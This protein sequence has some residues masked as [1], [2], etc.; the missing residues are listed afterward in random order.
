MK[1]S[2][3][4]FDK[5]PRKILTTVF[6]VAF[7]LLLWQM[8]SMLTKYGVFLASPTDVIKALCRQVVTPEFWG[9]VLCSLSHIL[10]GFGLAMVVG[11]LLAVLCSKSVF[12]KTF[13]SPVIRLVR[14]V[15]VVSFVIL[16]LIL[17]PSGM[18]SVLISF[19]MAM[20]VFY[21]NMSG[22][23]ESLDPGL[24]EMADIY[25]VKRPRRFRYLYLPQI[26]PGF[27][28][29]AV[30]SLGFAWKAGTTAEV[31]S[32]GTGSIGGM[33]YQAK[34]YLDT[35]ELFAWTLTVILCSIVTEKLLRLSLKAI[36]R[37]I[38]KMKK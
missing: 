21:E 14:T 15:P 6:S 4:K 26:Y 34:I 27:E 19:L 1:Q 17:L 5:K 7:W 35:P 10:S 8:I 20:P 24:D 29:A 22:A 2:C 11:C 3:E 16:A 12:L 13:F 23:L 32:S 18:L 38:L 33:L 9:T 37:L 30:L 36:Y 31:I 28:R 25:G